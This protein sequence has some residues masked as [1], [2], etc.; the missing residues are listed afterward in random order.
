M[1]S[2]LFTYDHGTVLLYF[3]IVLFS[4]FLA[5]V[6]KKRIIYNAD[7]EMIRT[8]D[9]Y[10]FWTCFIFVAFFAATNGVGADK[11]SYAYF[12]STSSFDRVF[13]GSEPGYEIFMWL[14]RY[15][16]KDSN[17]FLS[18]FGLVT[19]FNV[20]FGIWKLK[21]K[22]SIP[23]AVFIF[24]SQYYFQGF[25]LMRMYYAVSLLILFAHY[26][27]EGKYI[28]YGIGIL[29]AATFHYSMLFVFLAYVMS[30][31]LNKLLRENFGFK[32]VVFSALSI[33]FSAVAVRGITNIIGF[34]NPIIYKYSGYLSDVSLAN[35]GMKWIFNIIPFLFVLIFM[36]ML[37]QRN[38][39]MS[40]TVSYLIFSLVISLLSYS[41]PV[42]GRALIGFNLPIM[43]F[44]PMLMEKF[45]M[46]ILLEKDY[47]VCIPVGKKN[48]IVSFRFMKCIISIYFIL[49]YIIYLNEYMGIDKID[50][51]KFL[52][53]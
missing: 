46:K 13:T 27:Y 32:V 53:S 25:N 21:D 39:C 16:I 10:C 24:T 22:I 40:I 7:G 43:V 37:Y 14:L 23:W 51:F 18:L 3:F 49:A 29:I 38:I 19:V 5:R 4:T 12:F 44:L 48:L 28:K 35:T 47:S 52:W 17:V 20:F 9:K 34:S 6:S 11:P 33:C 42:I 1:F 2:D 8:Y 41:V 45:K 50:N 30:F 31:V 15:I 36:R 26:I